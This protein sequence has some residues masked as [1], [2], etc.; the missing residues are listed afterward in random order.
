MADKKKKLSSK[1]Q[2]AV[3]QL[4]RNLFGRDVHIVPDFEFKPIA[5]GQKTV[6]IEARIALDIS[7]LPESVKQEFRL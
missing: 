7:S 5:G 6:L 1:A 2:Y 4:I 3:D